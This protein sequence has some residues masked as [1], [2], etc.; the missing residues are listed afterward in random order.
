M[1]EFHT[2]EEMLDDLNQ[3]TQKSNSVTLNFESLAKV[4]T[5][6][7]GDR[8]TIL[9]SQLVEQMNGESLA[10]LLSQL[11]TTYFIPELEKLPETGFNLYYSNHAL[12]DSNRKQFEYFGCYS[13]HIKVPILDVPD[14]A[15]CM[16]LLGEDYSCH[17][18]SRYAIDFH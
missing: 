1:I 5:F 11:V 6:K 17:L 10:D 9:P 12:F 4:I 7:E 16:I 14:Q 18:M 13:D 2:P 8:F 15:K 3:L